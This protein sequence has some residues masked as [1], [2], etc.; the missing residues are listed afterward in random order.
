M[1]S[2]TR[3]PVSTPSPEVSSKPKAAGGEAP[4]TAKAGNQV[5]AEPA[6]PQVFRDGFEGAGAGAKAAKAGG[7]AQVGNDPAYQEA[8]KTQRELSGLRQQLGRV[9]LELENRNPFEKARDAITGGDNGKEKQIQDLKAKI[10]ALENVERAQPAEAVE[11]ARFTVFMDRMGE[12]EKTMG[13]GEAATI[14]RQTYYNSTVWNVGGGTPF[15]ASEGAIN[16]AGLPH[17]P[18]YSG[19]MAVGG[20]SGR[21]RTPDGQ[22]VD[23][24]HVACALDWQVNEKRVPDNYL[25]PT[26]PPTR[27]PNPFNL[28]TVTLTG[29][30]ASAIKNTARGDNA[31]ARADTAIGNEGKEDWYGDIDG[32]NLANRLAQNPNQSLTQVLG[33]YYGKGQYQNRIDEFATHSRYIQRDGQGQPL[34]DAQGHYVVDKQKLESEAYAF[35]NILSPKSINNPSGEVVNA[36]SRWFNQEQDA[37]RNN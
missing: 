14:A 24:G 19:G 23:M 3:R 12:L 6:H 20:Y 31:G 11:R 32:L 5:K 13:K 25:L 26:L 37:A 33:D 21:M 22:E 9:Q 16:A 29:D 15:G 8:L 30:V 34:R 27:I 18:N 2:T 1:S 35:A 7:V 4:T 10:S 17:D 28:Q 36:W